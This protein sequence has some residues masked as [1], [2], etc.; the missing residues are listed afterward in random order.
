MHIYLPVDVLA[1]LTLPLLKDLSFAPLINSTLIPALTALPSDEI[2]TTPYRALKRRAQ[3]LMMNHW[4]S[5]ALPNYYSYHLRLAQHP[6]ISLRKFMAGRI[7]QMHSQKSYLPDYPYC[8]DADDSPFCPFC[9]D[10]PEMFSHAI[11]CCPAKASARAHHLQAVSSVQHDAPLWYST[12]LLLSLAVFIKATGTPF[13]PDILSF[14]P[15]SPSLMGFPSSPF[16]PISVD[17]LASP[18]PRAL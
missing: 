1:Y 13:P 10:K 7:H 5:L 15:S 11:I 12:S 18:P 2:M 4:R 6:F 8:F 14:L 17:L 3:I 9:G 16:G